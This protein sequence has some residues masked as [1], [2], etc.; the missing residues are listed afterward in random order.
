MN[1]QLLIKNPYNYCTI[2]KLNYLMQCTKMNE[3]EM[4]HALRELQL[5]KSQSSTSVKGL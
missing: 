3:K 5:R 4:K 1:C 2:C